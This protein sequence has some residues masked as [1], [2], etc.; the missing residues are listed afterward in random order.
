MEVTPE[1]I[2]TLMSPELEN[3]EL[4]ILIKPEDKL[5]LVKAEHPEKVLLDSD[6]TAEGTVTLVSAVQ[7]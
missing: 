7:N 5:T 1:G 3:A 6:V 2:D 4:P